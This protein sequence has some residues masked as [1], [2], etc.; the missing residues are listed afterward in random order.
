MPNSGGSGRY[1]INVRLNRD[2][3]RLA[4]M[5]SM[6]GALPQKRSVM[7]DIFRPTGGNG[8]GAGSLAG[9]VPIQLFRSS[10]ISIAAGPTRACHIYELAEVLIAILKLL[11]GRKEDRT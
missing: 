2:R 3:C 6:T 4:V 9:H 1:I 10:N 8:S 7:I 5:V 11:F